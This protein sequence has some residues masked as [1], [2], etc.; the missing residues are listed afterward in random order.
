M[1]SKSVEDEERVC[2]ES[3][4]NSRIL[5]EDLGKEFKLKQQQYKNLLMNEA[6]KMDKMGEENYLEMLGSLREELE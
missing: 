1:V 4:L 3:L 2:G 6:V 5:T